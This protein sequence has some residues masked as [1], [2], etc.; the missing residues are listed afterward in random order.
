MIVGKEAA[1]YTVVVESSANTSTIHIAMRV[2]SLS[3]IV[4][5][6]NLRE[7]NISFNPLFQAYF[8]L[9]LDCAI[10]FIDLAKVMDNVGD[11]L[12]MLGVERNVSGRAIISY[13]WCYSFIPLIAHE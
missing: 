7:A 11:S 9:S 12:N 1:C 6:L 10:L 3:S 2:I 13:L 5:L 8:L 4:W